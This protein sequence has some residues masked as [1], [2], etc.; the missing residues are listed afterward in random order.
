MIASTAKRFL[1]TSRSLPLVVVY[2]GLVD[3]AHHI[4]HHSSW[5]FFCVESRVPSSFLCHSRS[6]VGSTAFPRCCRRRAGRELAR[7]LRAHKASKNVFVHEPRYAECSNY[8][9]TWPEL[10]EKAVAA[11]TVI[12]LDV[13]PNIGNLFIVLRQTVRVRVRVQRPK[14]V[15]L[16]EQPT[17][18]I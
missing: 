13:T 12:V 15:S 18:T 6:M 10:Q 2:V 16:G 8:W 4:I 5:C 17:Q 3:V 9:T 7:N 14:H 1:P 11:G